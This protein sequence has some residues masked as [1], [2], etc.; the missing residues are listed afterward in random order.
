MPLPRASRR[1]FAILPALL[2]LWIGLSG[3]R[4]SAHTATFASATV[5]IGSDRT[6]TVETRFD[7]LAFA[8]NDTPTRIGDA[9]MNALLDGPSQDLQTQ[10][11]EAAGRFH[12]DFQASGGVVDSI[13]FP[14]LADVQ[15]WRDS[16]IKQRLPLMETA[17]VTG[18]LNPD[19]KTIAV[20]FPQILGTVVVTTEVPYQEPISEPLDPGALSSAVSVTPGAPIPTAAPT[21]KPDTTAKPVSTPAK[22]LLAPIVSGA[23]HLAP[24]VT[25]AAPRG[26]VQSAPAAKLPVTSVSAI[27]SSKPAPVGSTIPAI[28]NGQTKSATAATKL[29]TPKPPAAAK[30]TEPKPSAPIAAV[31]S[32]TQKPAAVTETVVTAA[33][34]PQNHWAKELFGFVKMGFTHILPEGIDH[35][36]FVLGLFL[37]STKTKP[38]LWQITAFTV[39]HSLTLGL[40]LYGVVRLPSSIVEPLIAASIVF[41]A[42]ENVCTTELKPWRPFVVFGFGLVHGM[43]FAG[44]ITDLGLHRQ[45]FLTALIGFNAGVEL[46]QLSVVALAFLCVGW[47]RKRADYRKIVVIPASLAIAAIAVFWTIQRTIASFASL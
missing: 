32:L 38:L 14:S 1:R 47:L 6:F 2:A 30:P 12:N 20:Q 45:D 19:A 34:P 33:A 40:A 28:P 4:C 43:G 24:H 11:T 26:N 36:L 27:T 35:I 10:L 23:S 44:A 7:L 29:A 16:P 15:A 3:A 25:K 46:G 31:V 18:H 5:K 21:S 9:P 41:V 22:P 8:L 37:L 42:V 17:I 39:A 13:A